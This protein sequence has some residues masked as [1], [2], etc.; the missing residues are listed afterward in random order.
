[1]CIVHVCVILRI[2]VF[3]DLFLDRSGIHILVVCIIV[4]V[5]QSSCR[6]LFFNNSH[7]SSF[8]DGLETFLTLMNDVL[9]GASQAALPFGHRDVVNADVTQDLE[10][11]PAHTNKH[12]INAV[13]HVLFDVLDEVRDHVAN[14]LS[15][16]L[17]HGVLLSSNMVGHVGLHSIVLARSCLCRADVID[18]EH[19]VADV[20]SEF[21]VDIA[22]ALVDQLNHL[23]AKVVEHGLIICELL[24][25]QTKAWVAS[26]SERMDFDSFVKGAQV[27]RESFG[28][29]LENMWE[30]TLE[31]FLPA[32][33][34]VL[35]DRLSPVVMSAN[36]DLSRW[37]NLTAEH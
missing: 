28:T 17:K 24:R 23:A 10:V 32:V 12:L 7:I 36:A 20:W 3:L 19:G 9:D 25:K 30:T 8:K 16:S 5:L 11:I 4:L 6:S 26:M 31:G 18:S 35:I 27:V 15:G 21:T 37:S 22:L 13:G 34:E 14:Y 29:R 33:C 2:N 1:M